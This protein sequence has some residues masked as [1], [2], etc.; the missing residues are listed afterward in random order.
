M[1]GSIVDSEELANLLNERMI[2]KKGGSNQRLAIMLGMLTNDK[3]H[4]IKANIP[5]KDKSAFSQEKYKFFLEAPFE[6]SNRCCNVIKK[7]P[8]H[9]YH[10]ET[11]RTP[12]TGQMAS[13][14]RLRTQKWLANGCNG[15]HLKIPTSNPMSFWLEQD[16]LEYIKTRNLKIASPYGEIVPD[17]THS[18]HMD[19]QM[20]FDDLDT[21][22]GI[23]DLGIPLLRTTGC[24]RTGCCYCGFGSGIETN[25][26]EL[27]DQVSNPAIRDFC[28][29]GGAF[30][31]D[32]LWKPD[33]RGLGMWFVIKWINIRGNFK[34][35][36]PEEERYEA[37]FGNDLTRYYLYENGVYDLRRKT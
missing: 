19:G 30:D 5:S 34:I 10:K 32:G 27:I 35:I 11:G 31:K 7:D 20:R 14:S 26:Y 8:A 15:F 3:D 18:I 23:F 17:Y 2:N 9:R 1:T 12:I 16:V 21:S 28:M 25:R 37:E 13:E 33:N 29:R 24:P 6:I 22:L 4:P 36:I